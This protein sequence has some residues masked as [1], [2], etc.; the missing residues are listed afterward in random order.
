ME[1][2]EA[3]AADV[4]TFFRPLRDSYQLPLGEIPFISMG[5]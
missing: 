3:L 2:P 1:Q 4:A 5:R